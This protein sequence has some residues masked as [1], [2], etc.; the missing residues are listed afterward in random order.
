MERHFLLTFGCARYTPYARLQS[1][2]KC[3]V[4]IICFYIFLKPLSCFAY[5]THKKKMIQIRKSFR[6][7]NFMLWYFMWHMS[8]FHKP[9][10]IFNTFMQSTP[11]IPAAFLRKVCGTCCRNVLKS[12]LTFIQSLVLFLSIPSSSIPIKSICLIPGQ[13]FA[14]HCVELCQPSHLSKWDGYRN[15]VFQHF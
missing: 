13:L 7:L 10:C 1:T 5:K 8:H 2:D 14:G 11:N 4:V 9:N 3:L 6:I 15:V 12:L